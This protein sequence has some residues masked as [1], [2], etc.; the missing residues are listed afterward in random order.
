MATMFEKRDRLAGELRE[1]QLKGLETS[2][3]WEVLQELR[4]LDYRIRL[5]VNNIGGIK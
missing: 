1:I 3:G 2:R 5:I 4:E